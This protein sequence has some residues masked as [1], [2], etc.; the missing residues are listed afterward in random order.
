MGTVNYYLQ[1]SHNN[2]KLLLV[3]GKTVQYKTLTFRLSVRHC[4]AFLVTPYKSN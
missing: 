1:Q 4:T 3:F 2:V